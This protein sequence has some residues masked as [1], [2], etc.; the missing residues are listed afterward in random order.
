MSAREDRDDDQH[1]SD[2]RRDAQCGGFEHAHDGLPSSAIKLH[3]ATNT[4][5]EAEPELT[6]AKFFSSVAVFA[7]IGSI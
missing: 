7:C 1:L 3:F 6:N 5:W 4:I 2:R